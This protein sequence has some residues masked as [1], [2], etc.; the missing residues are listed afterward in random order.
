MDSVFRIFDNSF[1]TGHNSSPFSIDGQLRL[2]VHAARNLMQQQ[3]FCHK[4]SL[5]HF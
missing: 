1:P 5:T 2:L 4:V 3:D